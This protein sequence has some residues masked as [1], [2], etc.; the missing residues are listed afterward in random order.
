[1][2][3]NNPSGVIK[4]V[5]AYIKK[6]TRGGQQIVDEMLNIAFGRTKDDTPTYSIKERWQALKWLGDHMDEGPDFG[7]GPEKGKIYLVDYSKVKSGT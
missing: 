6:K 7:D 4:S 5:P 1:M 2:G 3:S